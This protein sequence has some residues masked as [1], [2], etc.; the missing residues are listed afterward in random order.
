MAAVSDTGLQTG[1][2]RT[3]QLLTLLPPSLCL[4]PPPLP[5]SLVCGPDFYEVFLFLL[6]SCTSTEAC[7]ARDRLYKNV[8]LAK[9]LYSLSLRKLFAPWRTLFYSVSYKERHFSPCHFPTMNDEALC[10]LR[11]NHN[12]KS[13]IQSWQTS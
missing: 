7:A 11:L 2:R 13:K 9:H 10:N 8:G 4:P 1:S 3:E 6:R 12:K 5:L